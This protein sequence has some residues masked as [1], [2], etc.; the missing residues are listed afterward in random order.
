LYEVEY[1]GVDWR[2]LMAKQDKSQTGSEIVLYQADDQ[3]PRIQVRLEAGTVWLSQAQMAEL[4][5]TTVPNINMHLKAIYAEGELAEAAT[6]KSPLIVRPEGSRRVQRSV[7]HY[8]LEATLAV[9]YRVRSA[10]GTQFRRWATELLKEYLVKGFVMDD[11]RLKNPPGPGQEDYFEQ[12]L[13]R[14]RDIRSSERVF[15]RKVLDIYATSV[16]YDPSAEASQRFFATVQNKMHWAV[17]GHTAA[18]IV[19]ERADASKPFMG[20]THVRPGGVVRK[21]DV[22]IAKNYLD[23]DELE[24]LNRTV[25]AYL[26]FAELQ[27]RNRRPMHMAE[28]IAKLDDFLRLSERPILDHTGQ[29]SH[30]Q[31]L[32]KAEE[33]FDRWRAIEDGKPQPVDRAFDAAVARLKQLPP[34]K[35]GKKT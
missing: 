14:I 23:A 6:I 25:N 13:A 34:R 4:Y 5:Q 1:A 20:L 29:V 15:W 26:E 28:W 21:A 24:T 18:E 31:A 9:G 30:E 35:P 33:E 22:G 12:L 27:A 2:L 19:R 32:R 16:D 11:E 3:A 8:N 7:K 10:R 17:H